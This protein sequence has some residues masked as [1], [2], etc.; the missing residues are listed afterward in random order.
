M[1]VKSEGTSPLIQ[2]WEYTN[3]P[4]YCQQR[5][6]CDTIINLPFRLVFF[7]GEWQPQ[8]EITCRINHAFFERN[9]GVFSQH[10]NLKVTH[11]CLPP[12]SLT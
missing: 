12:G 7:S 2:I 6:G 9:S 5:K 1:V 4:G 8:R 11:Q 10:Q 3:L